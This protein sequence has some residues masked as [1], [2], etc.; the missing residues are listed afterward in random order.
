MNMAGTVRHEGVWLETTCSDLSA[1]PCLYMLMMTAIAMSL[2]ALAKNHKTCE[3]KLDMA[4]NRCFFWGLKPGVGL[5]LIPEPSE[6][7]GLRA[8]PNNLDPDG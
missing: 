1:V 7:S 8:A 4:M 2:K 6:S 5:P 3:Y